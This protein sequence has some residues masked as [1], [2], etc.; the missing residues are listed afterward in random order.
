M[1]RLHAKFCQNIGN[2]NNYVIYD[3]HQF[4][5]G[6]MEWIAKNSAKYASFEYLYTS[7]GFSRV[8]NI[9]CTKKDWDKAKS[10]LTV[11]S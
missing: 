11:S 10:D 5:L 8:V 9:S 7:N 6:L 1:R 4:G 2:E 3:P